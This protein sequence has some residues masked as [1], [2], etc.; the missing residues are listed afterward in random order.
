[1]AETTGQERTESATPRRREQATREGDIARS[2]ELTSSLMLL[3][4]GL[5][6]AAWGGG[7]LAQFA[8]RSLV[9]STRVLSI[10]ELTMAGAVAV[11]RATTIGLVIALLPFAIGVVVVAIGGN[12]LQTRG[13]IAWGK[14]EPKFSH[15]NLMG[16]LKRLVGAEA[17]VQLVKS[18]VKL[19]VVGAATWLVLTKNWFQVTALGEMGAVATTMVLRS[20]LLRLVVTSGLAFLAVAAFDYMFQRWRHEQKLKMTRQE[21]VREHKE[22]E[23]DPIMKARILTMQRQ[24]ARQRMM[25]RVPSADVV[26][27]NPTHIAVAL[28][29]D[30][31]VAPAPLVVA[32]GERKV[33]ERIKQIAIAHGVPVLQN[34]PVARAL[35]A[36]AKVGRPIPPALYAAIAEI[37]AFVYRTRA[38]HRLQQIAAAERS[39][40]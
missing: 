28:R 26:I 13:A 30:V 10:G 34:K 36:T 22:S 17:Y 14:I 29:Y 21:V 19:A 31:T 15:L 2:P 11:I 37:L 4:G 40:G 23:G 5:V 8:Q 3:G 25:Q 12:L 27:V 32:M 9:E 6:L 39:D 16:G 38:P 20:L 7:A 35:L 1:V 18:I 24:R 33:A